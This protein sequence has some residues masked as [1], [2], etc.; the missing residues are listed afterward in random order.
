MKKFFIKAS[1]V[2]L[3]LFY[4]GSHGYANMLSNPGFEDDLTSWDRATGNVTISTSQYKDG[5]KSLR[6]VP[7]VTSWPNCKQRYFDVSVGEQ[8]DAAVWIRTTNIADG[9]SP[10]IRIM[11]YNSSNTVISNGYSPRI[12]GTRG[13]TKSS[14]VYSVPNN[15]VKI[16]FRLIVQQ[17]T[18]VAFFD[19]AS[20]VKLSPPPPS[21]FTCSGT[22][23][24]CDDFSS[25]STSSY[26]IDHYWVAGGLSQFLYDSSNQR[27]NVIGRDNSALSF[28]RTLSPGSS[29]S[30]SIAFLPT[31]IFPQ[32]GVIDLFLKQDENNHYHLYNS[33]GYG[34]GYFAKTVDGVEVERI[35]LGN[36]YSNGINYQININFTPESTTVSAFGNSIT[37]SSDSSVL[38]ISSF[39]FNISQ[40]TAYFDNII[41]ESESITPPPPPTGVVAVEPTALDFG[42]TYPGDAPPQK[43]LTITNYMEE[44]VAVTNYVYSNNEDFKLVTASG[45]VIL[46]PSESLILRIGF[47]ATGIADYDET[48]TISFDKHPDIIV[49]LTGS[50]L[51]RPDPAWLF[52]FTEETVHIDCDAGS[53]FCE[54]EVPFEIV[55]TSGCM[56]YIDP[57]LFAE[58]I[59]NEVE[60]AF[61]P[62]S[63]IH[64][65]ELIGD[66]SYG[67]VFEEKN[68]G[69]L[70]ELN[71]E[72]EIIAKFDRSSVS[73]ISE[74]CHLR[75]SIAFTITGENNVAQCTDLT[76]QKERQSVDEMS[77]EPLF[78]DDGVTP[79]METYDFV[80]NESFFLA[81]SATAHF[82][83]S[84]GVSGPDNILIAVTRINPGGIDDYKDLNYYSA[85][86]KVI[87]LDNEIPSLDFA[88][89]F[90]DSR[91]S[92]VALPS[93]VNIDLI[94]WVADGTV[95]SSGAGVDAHRF[96]GYVYDN[97]SEHIVR[98]IVHVSFTSSNDQVYNLIMRS[99]ELRL[100]APTPGLCEDET[101]PTIFTIPPVMR[102]PGAPTRPIYTN[103]TPLNLPDY[104]SYTGNGDTNHVQTSYWTGGAAKDGVWGGWSN[105]NTLRVGKRTYTFSNALPWEIYQLCPVADIA[106]PSNPHGENITLPG[107][108][109]GYFNACADPSLLRCPKES[110]GRVA[111][112]LTWTV[113]GWLCM[114]HSCLLLQDANPNPGAG[115]AWNC[116]E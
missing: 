30:F 19:G 110:D 94:E 65:P 98:A 7:G 74:D 67:I 58:Q 68:G 16:E 5:S 103:V 77:G 95:V 23:D 31:Q 2:L 25:D 92:F 109:F 114:K 28:S 115:E 96:E 29:G 81:S 4:F 45:N 17:G 46:A 15:V 84:G 78:E 61:N 34:P 62:C 26:S 33:N 21:G 104:Q 91:G 3:F 59:S 47:Y 43:T 22:E 39:T 10:R 79:I 49:P 38:D 101:A 88:L 72:C 63:L 8:Y 20:L 80:T 48:L 90:K 36:E 76:I 97:S 53:T 82:P 93:N 13:W 108:S 73:L 60:L 14:I 12:T 86:I 44:S 89:R 112:N 6:M 105:D 41:Y 50:V 66:P 24:F 71:A 116:E 52:F 55:S 56:G 9:A 75:G 40:Q 51:E 64:H 100:Y 42:D 87:S 57:I 1:I 69:C 27:V 102:P 107:T 106:L 37:L 35:S 11:G 54:G 85:Y 32:G 83:N 113:Y 111:W 99:N 18:G 70:S